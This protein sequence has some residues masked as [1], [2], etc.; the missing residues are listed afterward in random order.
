MN[1]QEKK[2]QEERTIEATSKGYMG[3]GGKFGIIM[4]AFGQPMVHMSEGGITVDT[5]YMEDPYETPVDKDQIRTH[6]DLMDSIPVMDM[7]DAVG[8][9]INEPDTPEWS[10]R[11]DRINYTQQDIGYHFDGLGRGM[12]L[13]MFYKEEESTILVYYK[14]Y[15]VFK[16][17]A[18]TLLGFNPIPEWE[19]WV[20]SL[21]KAASMKE[22][23]RRK[24]DAEESLGEA[25]KDRKNWWEQL[26]LRWGV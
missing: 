19:G 4:K 22:K 25:V 5:N 21:A 17:T 13:E 15:E 14:G 8:N 16:E 24:E 6:K 11:Q 10:E 12:H 1:D 3:I 18:G 9:P 26:R 23:K 7:F 2:I 20:E